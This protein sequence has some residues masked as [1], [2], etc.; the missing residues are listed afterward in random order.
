MLGKDA[1]GQILWDAIEVR[2]SWAEYVEQVPNVEDVTT[3]N[4]NVCGDLR[5]PVLRELYERA[6]SIDEVRK[7]VDEMKSGKAWRPDGFLEACLKKCG[8]AVI[9]WLERLLNISFEM[10]FSTYGLA[11]CKSSSHIQREGWQCECINS[12]GI[13]MLSV[14]GKLYGRVF[15]KRL[16]AGTE[17]AI[18]EG[19]CGFRFRGN[20]P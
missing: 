9:E 8:M 6:I 17:C 19:Q 15:I 12:R 7:A 4:I 13:S 10:G 16:M 5:M 18:A 20:Q 3:V 1:N 2:R 11:W 14:I